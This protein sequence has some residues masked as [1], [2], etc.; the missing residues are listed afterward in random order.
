MGGAKADTPSPRNESEHP[1]PTIGSRAVSRNVQTRGGRW[2]DPGNM[3]ALSTKEAVQKF[4]G[5]AFRIE[6]ESAS[7]NQPFTQEWQE[8]NG[9]PS[10]TTKCS[11]SFATASNWSLENGWTFSWRTIPRRSTY[12][13]RL[14][15][16]GVADELGR[17]AVEARRCQGVQEVSSKEAADDARSFNQAESVGRRTDH[18]I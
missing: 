12:A 14:S 15:A 17:A 13:T 5:C 4:S 3:M 8:A 7:E 10:A 18:R 1:F 16:G 9:R 2:Q 6:T 11:I